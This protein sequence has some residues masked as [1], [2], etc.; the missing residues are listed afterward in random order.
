MLYFQQYFQMLPLE[1][2]NLWG[3]ARSLK[4]SAQLFSSL[5]CT[6]SLEVFDAQVC[7]NVTVIFVL[8][9]TQKVLAFF[10][11]KHYYCYCCFS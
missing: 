7:L 4:L 9:L 1:V 10:E 3:V 5:T 8:Q 11:V 2:V 6:L